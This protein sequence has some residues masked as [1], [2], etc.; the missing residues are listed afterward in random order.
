MSYSPKISVADWAKVDAP[1]AGSIVDL[2]L[3]RISEPPMI[4]E[5]PEAKAVRY[6]RVDKAQNIF[7]YGARLSE[8][9]KKEAVLA[10][11]FA[12]FMETPGLITKEF[13]EH[14]A[15]W[16]EYQLKLR[17]LL[18]PVD[19]GDKVEIMQHTVMKSLA[20]QHPLSERD[21]RKAAHTNREG[22]GGDEAFMR[23]MKAVK[24]TGRIKCTGQNRAGRDCYCLETC[25]H[26]EA[27]TSKELERLRNRN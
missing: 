24:G 12:G 27:P 25:D 11:T 8:M 10:A 22:S 23:M 19:G 9:Y 20:K 6:G 3:K 1:Q 17:T 2:I 14:A 5:S 18:W 15:D 16:V 21:M 7:P 26:P 13:A 4:I